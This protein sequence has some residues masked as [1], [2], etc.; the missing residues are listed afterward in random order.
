A[1]CKT[2]F[3]VELD[4]TGNASIAV[5]DI[6]NSS[7]DNC[8][9]ESLTIDT[10]SFDCSNIG[11]NNV[12]LTVTDAAGNSSSCTTVVTVIDVTAPIVITQNISVELDDN[13]NA[14]ISAE[15]INDGSFDACGI[16]S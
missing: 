7:S 14:T 2:P 12:T 6:D 1:V 10:T 4:E 13:G 8:A 5:E 16:A 9:I 11:Q 3:T 15:E